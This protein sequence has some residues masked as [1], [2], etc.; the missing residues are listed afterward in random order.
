LA[1]AIGAGWGSERRSKRHDGVGLGK[2]KDRDGVPVAANVSGLG[3]VRWSPEGLP[4]GGGLGRGAPEA[5][6]FETVEAAG[7][8]VLPRDR[9]SWST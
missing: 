8:A 7:E 5:E 6:G 2:R 4:A 9:S 1:G 3:S